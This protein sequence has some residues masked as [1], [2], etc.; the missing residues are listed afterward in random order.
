MFLALVL[1]APAG[2]VLAIAL[3]RYGFSAGRARLRRDGRRVWL[4]NIAAILGSMAIFWYALG[5]LA[6]GARS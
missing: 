2:L 3:A 4:W 6:V 1:L 5:L